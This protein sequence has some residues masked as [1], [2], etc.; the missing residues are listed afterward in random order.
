MLSKYWSCYYHYLFSYHGIIIYS[1]CLDRRW[2]TDGEIIYRFS[3]MF[4]KHLCTIK[5][6]RMT[7]ISDGESV[8]IWTN[9]TKT[10]HHGMAK[11]VWWVVI[12]WFIPYRGASAKSVT[13]NWNMYSRQPS[14]DCTEQ[15]S[16][17]CCC[18]SYYF[19]PHVLFWD[20]LH[21]HIFLF[22]QIHSQAVPTLDATCPCKPGS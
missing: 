10:T 18:L 7:H 17:Y 21:L 14:A 9:Q 2:N 1:V 15:L 3:K 11:T 19:H 4:R 6:F 22:A 13:E 8:Q 5:A 12:S 20:S 16:S